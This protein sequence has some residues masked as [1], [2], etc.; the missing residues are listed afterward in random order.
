[1]RV[2]VTGARGFLGRHCV[3]RLVAAGHDVHGTTSMLPGARHRPDVV[4]HRIDLL[5]ESPVDVR[6]LT[7]RVRPDALLNLAWIAVP[8]EFWH[9]PENDAWHDTGTRLLDAFLE[10]GGQRFVGVGSGAEYDWNAAPDGTCAEDETPL[11][12]ATAYGRAKARFGRHALAR[13][14]EAGVPA[15]WARVFWPYG[16]GE[17][18]QRLVSSVANA[19]LRGEE[20][21]CSAGT[22]RRDF[23]YVGDVA[24]ILVALLV[25][26]FTGAVNV[27]SG[28][29]TA[30]RDVALAVGRLLGREE[31][32]RFGARGAN[33]S[34]PPV[35]RAS[36][37]RLRAAV[38]HGC[39]TS[40]E[41]GLRRTVE[42]LTPTGAT[43]S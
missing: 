23:V 38:G 16:P 41:D 43:T 4:W 7:G 36:V 1:M 8:G 22:Q 40:L 21:R 13:C 34:E 32:I 18:P 37:A 33:E 9:A 12:A 28:E 29:A 11:D 2:L 26:D 17:S 19:L 3:E 14:A 5:R 6:E 31:L 27:G 15:A 30:V 10:R 35:V 24:K 25:N 20:A 39:S 42:H